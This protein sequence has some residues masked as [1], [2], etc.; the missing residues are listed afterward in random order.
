MKCNTVLTIKSYPQSTI[1]PS[2]TISLNRKTTPNTKQTPITNKQTIH[3]ISKSQKLNSTVV[4]T[5]YPLPFICYMF[6]PLN[7]L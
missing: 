3:S 1:L 6:Y 7:G 5:D 4:F 2:N